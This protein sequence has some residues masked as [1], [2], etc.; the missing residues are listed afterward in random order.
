MKK[1][2]KILLSVCVIELFVVFILNKLNFEVRT[3]IGNAIGIFLCLLP[4]QIL[5]F[6]LGWDESV[7]EIKRIC[8]KLLFIFIIAIYLLGG[9][10]SL[11]YEYNGLP[12]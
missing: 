3:W 9:L 12:F 11:V 4:I 2:Y 1:R 6:L 10:L 5:L 7:G 8:F